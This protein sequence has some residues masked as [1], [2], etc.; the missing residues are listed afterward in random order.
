MAISD[1]AKVTARVSWIIGSRASAFDTTLSDDRF[2]LEELRRAVLETEAEVVRALCESYHPLRLSFLAWSAD[3]N[4]EDPI[5]AHI[6]QV[7]AVKIKPFTG[8]SYQLGESTSRQNIRAWRANT[9]SIFD[10][11]AH[12]VT[13]SALA[14]YYNITNQTLTFTGNVAQVKIAN[15]V[16]DYTTPALQV[17]SQFDNALVAGAVPRLNK[18][19]VPQALVQTYGALYA[20]AMQEIRSG[21]SAMPKLPEAQAFE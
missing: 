12:D 14:G 21:S 20:A 17:D 11:V 9:G 18:L 7:E 4:N 15:Y 3:L 6:G 5:P 2:I 8:G 1:I 13:G 10:A 19:G 16:P